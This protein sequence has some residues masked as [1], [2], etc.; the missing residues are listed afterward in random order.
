[1]LPS[2]V[3]V[4]NLKHFTN[5]CKQ[6]WFTQLSPLVGSIPKTLSTSDCFLVTK[7][8]TLLSVQNSSER[9]VDV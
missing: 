2:Q 8:V 3:S 7:A 6:T 5:L 1:M 9:Y 4:L